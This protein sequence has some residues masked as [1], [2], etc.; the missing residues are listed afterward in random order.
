MTLSITMLFNYAECHYAECHILFTIVL[1]VVML[2]VIMIS[3][4]VPHNYRALLCCIIYAECHF[5]TFY[6]D[7]CYSFVFMLS[8][9]V[10]HTHLI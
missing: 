2:C 3:V 5:Q 6:A 8:V 10:T 1:N 9:L 4:V 7:C